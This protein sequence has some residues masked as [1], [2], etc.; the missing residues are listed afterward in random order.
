MDTA[1]VFERSLSSFSA[2][3]LESERSKTLAVSISLK[4]KAI[5]VSLKIPGLENI[6]EV[7]GNRAEVGENYDARKAFFATLSV[8]K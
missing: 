5:R 6:L 4:T 2:Q 3:K 1:K 7:A 8:L